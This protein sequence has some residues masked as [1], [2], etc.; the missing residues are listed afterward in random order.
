MLEKAVLSLHRESSS[1]LTIGARL[2]ACGTQEAASSNAAR[3]IQ[4]AFGSRR[5][6]DCVGMSEE[7]KKGGAETYIQPP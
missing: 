3:N 6:A 4:G 2:V 5:L 7:G 1:T